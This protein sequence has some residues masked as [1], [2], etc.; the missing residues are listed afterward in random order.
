MSQTFPIGRRLE[1]YISSPQPCDYIKGN[2]SQNIFISPEIKI[3]PD[4]YQYLLTIGF[5]RSGS[6]AYRPH[7]ATCR[8]C[9][10]CRIDVREFKPSKSQRRVLAKNSPVTFT[11]VPSKFIEEHYDLYLRYQ[12]FKH[13]KGSMGRFRKLEYEEFLCQS[14]GHTLMYETRLDGKLLAVSVTDVFYDALSAVYTFFDPDYSARSLGTLSIL[15][16]IKAA[17]NRG[18]KHLYLGYFIQNSEK[19]AYKKN[20]MPIEMLIEGEWRRYFKG[21]E[22]PDQSAPLDSAITF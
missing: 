8:S 2:E 4:I 6:H 20:F 9:I 18:K 22:L 3:T 19:M 11:S 15:Q 17:K 12:A 14:F 10:S 7:C 1:L 21:D 16:Q 13:P 5:R